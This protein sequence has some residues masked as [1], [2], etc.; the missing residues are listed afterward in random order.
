M[1][2]NGTTVVMP[3]KFTDIVMQK[4]HAEH[5]CEGS[6]TTLP[7]LPGNHLP[8]DQKCN[9]K[10]VMQFHFGDMYGVLKYQ[11]MNKPDIEK[12]CA[13]RLPPDLAGVRNTEN[14]QL[15]KAMTT[16]TS[17]AHPCS[18]KQTSVICQHKTSELGDYWRN[19]L[20]PSY[21]P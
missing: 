21:Q 1:S 4:K 15:N 8:I 2:Q 11:G 3:V 17:D 5:C 6:L 14:V 13:A 10:L 7:S 12:K 19:K 18:D 9:K 20:A 16:V